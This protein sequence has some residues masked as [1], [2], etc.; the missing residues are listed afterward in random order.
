MFQ[1]TLAEANL[2]RNTIIA[3]EKD[4]PS[5]SPYK[6]KLEN[7]RQDLSRSIKNEEMRES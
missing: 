3:Y 2:L 1:I 6:I 4:I 7:L 5:G